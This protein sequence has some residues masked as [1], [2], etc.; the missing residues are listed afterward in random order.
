VREVADGWLNSKVSGLVLRDG[1]EIYEG[2]KKSLWRKSGRFG[3]T[4]FYC[5]LK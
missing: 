2:D 5:H 4:I 3:A 1:P